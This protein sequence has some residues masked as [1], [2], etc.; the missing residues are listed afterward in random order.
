MKAVKREKYNNKYG[1]VCRVGIPSNFVV[2]NQLSYPDCNIFERLEMEKVY[3]LGYNDFEDMT[4]S[5]SYQDE[6]EAQ[7]ELETRLK[8]SDCFEAIEEEYYIIAEY[9]YEGNIDE[10][11]LYDFSLEEILEETNDKPEIYIKGSLIDLYYW[12]LV[13]RNSNF[14][15]FD[16]SDFLEKLDTEELLENQYTMYIYVSDSRI[17]WEIDN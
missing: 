13:N 17:W 3:R 11:D 8:E 5:G 12:I 7:L 6:Y 9:E 14:I 15:R 10:C 1:K 16:R 2:D 4:A